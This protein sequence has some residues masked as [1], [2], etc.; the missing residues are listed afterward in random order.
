MFHK[1]LYV[2]L[3]KTNYKL[4]ALI[5]IVLSLLIGV[6]MT[7]FT[8][9]TLNQISESSANAPINPLGD[10]STLI[11]FVA[12]QYFGNFVLLFTLIYSII[13]G[14][15]LIASQVDNGSL[16]YQLAHPITRT[17]FTFT[18]AS[19]FVSSLIILFGILFFV[20]YGVAEFVQPGELPVKTF[21]NLTIGSFILT[22]ALSSITFFAS[23]LFNRSSSSLTLGAGLTVFFYA[24]NLLSGLHTDLE[25]LKNVTLI[26]LFD[27]A[28]IVDGDD[29]VWGL[30]IL[31]GLAVFLYSAGILVFKRKDLPL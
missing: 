17:Q 8:P 18:S 10:I 5:T 25:G 11:S 2:H 14:N 13:L 27:S 16:A 21:F 22:L 26:T 1:S 30:T 12:N 3:F 31:I 15:K 4:F 9:E 24:A 6:V 28:A 29:Y 20:G 7:M 19:Y 23:C